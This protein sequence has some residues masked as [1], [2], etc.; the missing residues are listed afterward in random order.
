MSTVNLAEGR[1]LLFLDILGFSEITRNKSSAEILGVI[2]KAFEEFDRWEELNGLFETIYFS[3]TFLFYQTSPGYH[4]S[5]FLDIYAIGAFVHTALLSEGIAT[6]GAIA[7]GGFEVWDTDD[8]KHQAYFG[9]ALVEA[10]EAERKEGWIG[11]TILPSAWEPFEAKEPGIVDCFQNEG[12]WI[13]REDNVLLLNPFIKLRSWYIHDQVEKI[14]TPYL[15]WDAP[16][17]PNEIKAFN[18]LKETAESYTQKVDFIGKI[19]SKYHN[20]MNFLRCAFGEELYTWAYKLATES[21]DSPKTNNGI[22][23]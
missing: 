9:T 14:T 13:K 6:R 23:E 18:F 22:I 11:I 8:G 19:A 12:V 5:C 1:H 10:H 20:T 2:S 7:F 4:E 21:I 16:E 17:F 15:E 3:D